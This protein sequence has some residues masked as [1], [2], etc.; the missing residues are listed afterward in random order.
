MMFKIDLRTVFGGVGVS[1]C[2]ILWGCGG[3]GGGSPETAAAT[4]PVDEEPAA[5]PLAISGNPATSI[6]EGLA[7]SFTP[8]VSGGISS[9]L[10]FSISNMPS[11]ASFDDRTGALTGT[12]GMADMGMQFPGITIAVNDGQEN[13]SLSAFEIT[14]VGSSTG[15]ATLSW[16]APTENS[17]STPLTDLS[18]YTVYYGT[19][20]DNY[21][22]SV[23]IHNPSITINV[24][25]NL[26]LGTWYFVVTAF[27][28]SG[29]ESERSNFASA[30]IAQ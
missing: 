10:S 21:P 5:I 13:V 14:V 15:S 30:T 27:D 22:N 6:T 26:S 4:S 12:P 1:L 9:T 3:G 11:W 19:A 28:I 17:D 25:E 8:T 24:I 18:G 29:N 23:R 2:L 7:Y 16:T 20:V